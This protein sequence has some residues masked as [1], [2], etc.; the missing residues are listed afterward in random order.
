MN[1]ANTIHTHHARHAYTSIIDSN[2]STYTRNLYTFQNMEIFGVYILHSSHILHNSHT[3]HVCFCYFAVETKG[4]SEMALNVVHDN[5]D[6]FDPTLVI[7][8]IALS[9]G[10]AL[11]RMVLAY[12]NTFT[13][14]LKSGTVGHDLVAYCV[15]SAVFTA[16]S[17]IIGFRLFFFS[18]TGADLLKKG[19]YGESEEAKEKLVIPMLAYQVVNFLICA[20]LKEYRTAQFIGHHVVTAMLSYFA[21][22]PFAQYYALFFFGVA[23]TSSAPLGVVDFFKNF[24]SYADKYPTLN[25]ALRL[26]FVLSFFIIR[27]F[28]WP[29]ISFQFWLQC[30]ELLSAGKAHSNFVV[31]FFLFANIFLTGLQFFWATLI[32]KQVKR[33]LYPRADKQ[34]K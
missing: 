1:T 23:E 21:C 11:V 25:T 5:L 22:A 12:T 7:W 14:K 9:G 31:Y 16:Y 34:K 15:M 3:M 10:Y 20:L 27:V 32:F 13:E 29:I 30:F 18:D 33:M 6:I 4:N 26:A 17:A 19:L 2:Y 24:R 28:V 8:I